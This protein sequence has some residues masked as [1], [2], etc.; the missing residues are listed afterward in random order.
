MFTFHKVSVDEWAGALKAHRD[1]A[2]SGDDT[3]L[4]TPYK[5]NVVS[6][7][8]PCQLVLAQIVLEKIQSTYEVKE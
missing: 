6:F 2:H 8:V 7:C 4:T 1:S 5:G 3:V